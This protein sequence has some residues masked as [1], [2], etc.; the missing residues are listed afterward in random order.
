[1]T[2]MTSL[3]LRCCTMHAS[4]ELVSERI[5]CVCVCMLYECVCMYACAC[6]CAQCMGMFTWDAIVAINKY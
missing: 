1:M 2:G 4:L 3:T 5:L 6:V